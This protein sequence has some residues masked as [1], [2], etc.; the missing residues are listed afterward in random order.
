MGLCYI[1]HACME[2]EIFSGLKKE[3]LDEFFAVYNLRELLSA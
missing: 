2:G 1:Q 3:V